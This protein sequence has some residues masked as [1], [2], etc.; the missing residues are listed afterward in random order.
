M[1]KFISFILAFSFSFNVFASAA[2][3]ELEKSID[4]Y[5]YALT[6]DWDQKD[7]EAY[8]AHTQAFFAKM[9]ALIKEQGL[10]QQDVIAL[11]EKKISNKE[12]LKSLQVKLA[13][14]GEAKNSAELM[15][16]LK[17]VQKDMYAQGASWNGSTVITV[18]IVVLVVAVVGYAIWFSAN[19][20]CVEYA[21]RWEC[22]SYSNCTTY[23]YCYTDTVCGWD[24]Y[25]VRYEKK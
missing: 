8:D 13:L 22:N 18:G 24:D 11:A 3:A 25:C 10:T 9:G 16:I 1:K 17:D 23:N 14:A 21:E 2:T 5:Q 19:H 20:R 7:Q 15:N 12:A 6:V 4:E